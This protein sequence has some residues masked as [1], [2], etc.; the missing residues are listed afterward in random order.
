MLLAAVAVALVIFL[1]VSGLIPE[2]SQYIKATFPDEQNAEFIS[3]FTPDPDVEHSAPADGDVYETSHYIYT[4]IA[5]ENGW[6][7]SVKDKDKTSYSPLNETIYGLPIVSLNETFKDCSVMVQAPSVP[8]GVKDMTSAFSGC[9]SLTGLV[10]VY[11]SPS[12]Y[13]GC[14]E[15]TVQSVSLMGSS[16]LLSELSGTAL[17]GNVS[18]K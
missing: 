16:T 9:S 2:L 7:V 18:V 15:G 11:A 8:K 4:F 3:A 14:F 10:T 12:L 13:T 17:S 5:A 6:R 1:T